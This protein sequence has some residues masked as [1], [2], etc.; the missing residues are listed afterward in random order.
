MSVKIHDKKELNKM[1]KEDRLKLLALTEREIAHVGL[2]LQ[3]KAAKK[4]DQLQKL[5]KQ[6]AQIKTFNRL[7]QNA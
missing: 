6:R 4:S 5:K 1:S 2:Q 3:M 7:D